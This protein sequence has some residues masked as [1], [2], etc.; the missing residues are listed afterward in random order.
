[1]IGWVVFLVSFVI[2]GWC[3]ATGTEAPPILVSAMTMIASS[4][5]VLGLRGEPVPV[6]R[7]PDPF[8]LEALRELD[9]EFPDE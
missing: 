2:W 7:E 5:F 8:Y 9:A 4:F 3:I 6:I 1:M